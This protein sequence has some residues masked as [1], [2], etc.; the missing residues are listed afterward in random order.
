[1][2]RCGS[3]SRGMTSF[4]VL[5]LGV[6]LASPLTAP[7]RAMAQD[8]FQVSYDSAER[9]RQ[10]AELASDVE[11][12]ERHLSLLKKVVKLVSPAVVHIEAEKSANDSTGYGRTGMVEEAGSGVIVEMQGKIYILTN[13]HVVKMAKPSDIKI[14]LA[15]SREIH[16]TEVWADAGTDIAVM[17]VSAPN[18]VSVRFGDSGK[19]EIG[20][21]V[22]AV[23]SPFGLSRSVT[24][25]IISATGRRDLDLGDEGVRFQNFIQTDAAINPGNSGGPLLNLRG[26][27]VGI[28]T[29]IASSSGGN[30]GIG[31]SIPINM[32]RHIATQLIE[33]G[34]V[35]RA[36]LG[37]VLDSKF[38][39]TVAT[40]MGLPRPIGARINAITVGSPAAEARLQ[41]DD[42]VLQFNGIVIENDTHLVNLVALTEVG[43]EVPIVV[44][45]Q[46]KTLR[47]SVKVGDRNAFDLQH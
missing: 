1:M 42:V 21:F 22:I 45:R 14:K 31:F 6:A 17:S 24:Y 38:G 36:F 8:D 9:D 2:G 26:E 29:A 33:N 46:G 25:G 5:L 44:Y 4:G 12:L 7:T 23:G 37:V 35:S 10:Y 28:N 18:L 13:R 16:P 11:A 43:K 30:E 27:L 47:M 34:A 15:D 39:P 19:M 41:V 20:D 40:Q 3:L 32:V